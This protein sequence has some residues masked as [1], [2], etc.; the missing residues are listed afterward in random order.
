MP[1]AELIDFKLEK[2]RKRYYFDLPQRIKRPIARF[3]DKRFMQ[4]YKWYDFLNKSQYW[5]YKKMKK[6]Q[7][8]RLK[9]IS[10]GYI[11]DW[12][13]FYNLPLTSKED[14]RRWNEVFDET[15]K[16][17][18]FKFITHQ[19]SGSTGEPL[20]IYGPWFLQGLKDAVFERAWEWCGWDR[21]G[22]ILRL[23]AGEPKWGW[24]DF[25]RNVKPLSYRR[26][27]QEHLDFVY[28]KKPFMIHGQSGAI[29]ELTTA[30]IKQGK[31]NILKEINVF[32]MSEDTKAHKEALKDIYKEVYSGY[33]LAELCTI[34][35]ECKYHQLHV[36]METTIVEVIRGEIVITDLWND[37]TPII[38]YRT[39]DK[40]EIW[41]NT[42]E[43]EKTC[44]YT[45]YCSC[46]I[47]HD[48]LCN[49]E[50]RKIDY[51]DGPEVKR[52]IGWWLVSPISHDY[53]DII[54]KWRVEIYPKKKLMIL[55]IVWNIPTP[56][57]TLL[58]KYKKFVKKNAGL[59][60]EIIQAEKIKDSLNLVR[61]K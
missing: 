27:T 25:W 7:L 45:K 36:N 1:K 53:C 34:A 31:K 56:R 38:R 43:F 59:D 16:F 22:W 20:R 10:N 18:K 21:K 29:R 57:D 39:G 14:I 12:D 15:L 2:P 33:G 48:I 46:G 26:I 42:N 28:N 23:T 30:M 13:D 24:F 61:V 11:Q 3:L 44:V 52:P 51:Y 37:I 6:F 19:T 32:L 17:T 58:K 40:G 49:I 5:N 8:E 35:S 9:I 55:F 41:R 47:E 60:L 50:G 4:I 54:K